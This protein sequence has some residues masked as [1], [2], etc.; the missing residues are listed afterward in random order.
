[1]A[2]PETSVEFRPLGE[3]C[4]DGNVKGT[5]T[6]ARAA[7][8][9]RA[10]AVMAHPAR[11]QILDAL[12]SHAGQVCVCDLDGLLPV[13][14]PTVSHHLR[15]LREAGLVRQERR[16]Q[17]M[18]YFVDREVLAELQDSV[19]RFFGVLGVH[20]LPAAGRR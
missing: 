15:L 11:L 12:A 10:L 19:G 3:R 18:F 13:K 9:A 6:P 20:R 16:G 7:K 4:C 8:L 14:Q 17:W 1:M 2:I 5:L